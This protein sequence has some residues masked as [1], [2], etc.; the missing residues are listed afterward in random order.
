MRRLSEVVF[1]I[2]TLEREMARILIKQSS[3]DETLR[4]YDRRLTRLIVEKDQ[5][6]AKGQ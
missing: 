2:E 6:L 4:N 1:D 5:I 3:E